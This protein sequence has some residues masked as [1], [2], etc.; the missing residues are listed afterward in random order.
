MGQPRG[1]FFKEVVNLGAIFEPVAGSYVDIS[2]S[3]NLAIIALRGSLDTEGW[4]VGN[5]AFPLVDNQKE[6]RLLE[7]NRTKFAGLGINHYLINTRQT[8]FC[9]GNAT[10]E[11]KL[12]VMDN[13]IENFTYTDDDSEVAAEDRQSYRTVPQMFDLVASLLDTDYF[14]VVVSYH[15]DYGYPTSIFID[16]EACT[17]DEELT[18]TAS[19]FM[20]LR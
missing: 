20:P 19:D 15:P 17:V 14:R 10:R 5:M 6:R 16:R 13:W 7:E 1:S 18:I 8:C 9:A 2:A 11:V 4:I 12:H 3:M